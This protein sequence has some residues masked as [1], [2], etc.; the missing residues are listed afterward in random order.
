MSEPVVSRVAPV[1]H[2]KSEGE[3]RVVVCMTAEQARSV[4]ARQAKLWEAAGYLGEMP[5]IT[6]V[7]RTAIGA[8]K[9]GK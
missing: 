2:P 1:G 7:I 8:H 3:V 9:G 6:D 5:S 4:R